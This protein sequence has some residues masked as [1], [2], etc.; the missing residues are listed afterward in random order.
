MQL[1][2]RGASDEQTVG[3]A[4]EAMGNMADPE[5]MEALAA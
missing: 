2:L 1:S 5:F 4:L 3:V